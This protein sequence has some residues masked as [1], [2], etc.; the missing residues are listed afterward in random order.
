MS[1]LARP[2]LKRELVVIFETKLVTLMSN[3]RENTYR[4]MNFDHFGS[5][6]GARNWVLCFEVKSP[7]LFITALP[8]A[9]RWSEFALQSP[10]FARTYGPFSK[11]S[12]TKKDLLYHSKS[13]SVL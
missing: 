9:R 4:N 10:K 13:F 7:Q 5:V 1:S 8:K 3:V 11:P 6:M 12:T 2:Y